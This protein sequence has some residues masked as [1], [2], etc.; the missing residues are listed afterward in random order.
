VSLR[1]ERWFGGTD[2][3]GCI[4]RA[5]LHA[6]GISRAALSGGPVVGICNSWSELVNG[7]ASADVPAIMI[8][9]G[10]SQPALQADEG[11]D[12]DFLRAPPGEREPTEPCGLLSRWVGGW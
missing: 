1:S 10:P 5:S 12:F 4:H 6:E 7:A 2:V 3:A 9:G 11:C 8:T